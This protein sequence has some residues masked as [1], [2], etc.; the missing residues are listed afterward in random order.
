MRTTLALVVCVAA[1][2][3]RA[4]AQEP[5][6]SPEPSPTKESTTASLA[7]RVVKDPGGEPVKK[8]I[9][10]L[11]G[12]N[13]EEGGNY[14]ATSDQEGHFKVLAIRPGRYHMFVERPGFL[15]VDEKHRQ[16]TGLTLSFE[17]GQEVK[18]QV[19]R[20]LPAAI[21]NGRVIDEDGD[22]MPDVQVWVGRKRGGKFKPDPAGAAQTNDLGEYRIGGLFPGKYYGL[23]TPLPNFQTLIQ[24]QRSPSDPPDPS[25]D[26][27]Y[28]P[29]FYPNATTRFA[30]SPI[31][32]HAG[33]DVPVDF[34]LARSHTVH[35]RGTVEG[36]EP[37][38]K[39]VVMLGAKDASSM[40][41]T[42]ETDKDGKFELP[43]VAPGSFVLMATTLVSDRPQM[44]QR[45]I[46]VGEANIDDLRLAPQ[47]LATLR[48]RVHF[49][50]AVPPDSPQFVLS[51]SSLNED[52]E[53]A[54]NIAVSLDDS[55]GFGG[56]VKLKSDG[57]F[58]MK[59]VPPGLYEV[60]V[61]SESKA[62][63][64]SYVESIVAGMKNVIDTGLN[65]SGGT[66]TLEITVS[67]GAGV[68]DGTVIN[69]KGEAVPNATVVAVP[70]PKFRKHLDRYARVSTDQSGHFTIRR[71]RP[72]DYEL[73][74][75][76]TLDG[77]EYRDPDF[78]SAVEGKATVTKIEQ[79]AHWNVS[80]KLIPAAPEQP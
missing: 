7:G 16:S 67:S 65:V 74:A 59:N 5:A 44:V 42:T 79:S 12:E 25:A 46:E 66:L 30:A 18:D 47:P 69:D 54:G 53:Y 36:L 41:N 38:V 35:I 73:F 31:E 62:L 45:P 29:T 9:I 10:E 40:F 43:H 52:D 37:G 55:R 34:S 76:E 13:H 49:P 24:T 23:A 72:G 4:A 26:L 51:L 60:D 68:V 56:P 8:A 64:D 11:I 39:A 20:M 77:D 75:W 33:D 6:S 27:S 22:P 14:T 58:E 78:L 80:L 48:G 2:L 63:A 57:S 71:L 17:A 21:I 50:K 61:S 32:L 19:L 28:V 3:L 1:L 70:D 15:A